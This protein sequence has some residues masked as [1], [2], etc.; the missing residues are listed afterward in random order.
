MQYNSVKF[1]P[2]SLKD[3]Q[4]LTLQIIR[5]Q[6]LWRISRCDFIPA[7]LNNISPFHYQTGY[8]SLLKQIFLVGSPVS[9]HMH[10]D[11][12]IGKVADRNICIGWWSIGKNWVAWILMVYMCRLCSLEAQMQEKGTKISPSPNRTSCIPYTFIENIEYDGW[13]HS[14]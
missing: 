8:I 12:T 2:F 1:F 7:I 3:I 14:N 10:M 11:G 6:N 13:L 4:K 5:K 9:D